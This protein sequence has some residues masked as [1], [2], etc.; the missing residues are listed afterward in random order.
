[1]TELLIRL[2]VKDYTNVR[3]PQVR[4]RYGKFAGFVGIITNL[5]LFLGKIIAGILFSS[6]SIIADAVNNL[7]G[8]WSFPYRQECPCGQI[9]PHPPPTIRLFNS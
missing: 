5:L 3:S 6:V 7:S 4:E 9:L 8:M 2:F 1:M